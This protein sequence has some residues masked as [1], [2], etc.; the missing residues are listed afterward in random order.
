MILNAPDSCDWPAHQP[1]SSIT[2]SPGIARPT[3]LAALSILSVVLAFG[4][5]NNGG[6][7]SSGTNGNG[8]GATNGA[9]ANGGGGDTPLYV[10]QN[11]TELPTGRVS[12][13]GTIPGVG[14][15]VTFDR[16]RALEFLGNPRLFAEPGVGNFMIGS[17][18]EPTIQRFE[19]TAD[20]EFEPGAVVSLANLGVAAPLRVRGVLFVSPTKAYYVDDQ[21]LLLVIWNPSD[22]TITDSIDLSS[23]LLREGLRTQFG[24]ASHRRGDEFILTAG[25]RATDAT[26]TE[27]GMALV[28]I[29]STTDTVRV[30]VDPRCT[31]PGTS[32]ELPNDDLVFFNAP[33][34]TYARFTTG[35]DANPEDCLMVLRAGEASFGSDSYVPMSSLVQGEASFGAALL[36]GSTAWVRVLDPELP[37]PPENAAFL[38]YFLTPSWRWWRVDLAELTMGTI[39]PTQEPGNGLR[40]FVIRLDGRSFLPVIDVGGETSTLLDITANPPVAMMQVD[41]F[42]AEIVRVL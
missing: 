26:G 1:A 35:P 5:G 27:A 17:G 2:P 39:D 25:W 7:G 28:T 37:S 30:E 32:V 3:R 15:E 41:G 16:T 8:T 9:G 38:E 12:F 21:Q 4:C 31:V 19:V 18:E 22:M 40:P 13:V 14:P 20:G 10:L 6:S 24:T 34:N 36:S 33:E 23:E 29:D 11:G 42:F